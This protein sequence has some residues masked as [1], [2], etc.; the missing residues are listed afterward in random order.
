MSLR[1]SQNKLTLP[2]I[3]LKKTFKYEVRMSNIFQIIK[4]IVCTKSFLIGI[5]FAVAAFSP[6][7][8]GDNNL[9]EDLAELFI[10]EET[11]ITVDFTPEK[12]GK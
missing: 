5:A 1:G 3:K 8:L 6:Y 7:I 2:R 10:K 4:D 12:V 11:G 9:A